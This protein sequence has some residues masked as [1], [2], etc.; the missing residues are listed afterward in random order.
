[1]GEYG[2]F[3]YFTSLIHRNG[4]S[5]KDIDVRASYDFSLGTSYNIS[6]NLKVSLKGENLLD[7]GTKSL[8]STG[9]SNNFA[10]E[11]SDRV[12]SLSMKWVF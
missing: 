9:L 5:Y 8:Y 10:L 11:D 7:K 4:Y 6:K 1:M 12:I 2:K 3:E